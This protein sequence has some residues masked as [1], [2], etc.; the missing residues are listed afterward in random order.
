MSE[1]P[2][3]PYPFTHIPNLLLTDDFLNDYE[4]IRFIIYMMRRISTQPTRIPLKNYCKHLDLDPFEFMFGRSGFSQ[5]AGISEK[6]VRTRLAQLIGLGYVEEVVNKRASTFRVYRLVKEAF[7][8]NLGQHQG[9][10]ID[11]E[12]GRNLG[13]KQ[14]TKIQKEK[15]IER[16]SNVA[17]VPLSSLENEDLFVISAYCE[18]NELDI[19]R[20]SIERWMILYGV[21]K[22]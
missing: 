8:R 22:M 18:T 12:E 1:R 14:E 7:C 5:A 15:N 9:Q 16:T 21:E 11:H 20:S 2:S 13:H 17:A 4:M 3:I 19:G 6:I 10:Q